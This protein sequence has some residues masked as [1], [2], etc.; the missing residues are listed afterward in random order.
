MTGPDTTIRMLKFRNVNPTTVVVGFTDMDPEE[1]EAHS[2]WI[3][4][5]KQWITGERAGQP[6]EDIEGELLEEARQLMHL[7]RRKK[8]RGIKV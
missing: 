2:S 4:A 3:R 1:E 8:I 5:R 6:E 7:S